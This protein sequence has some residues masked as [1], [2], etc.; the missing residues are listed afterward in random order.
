[1]QQFPQ[2]PHRVRYDFW[3]DMGKEKEAQLADHIELLKNRRRFVQTVRDGIRLIDDLRQGKLDVLFELFPWVRAEF[4]K[5]M[6]IP[7]KKDHV[8]LEAQLKRLEQLI[9]AQGLNPVTQDE[10]KPPRVAEGPKQLQVPQ[11]AAPQFDDDDDLLVEVKS[12]ANTANVAEN[13]IR[14]IRGLLQQ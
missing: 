8:D 2:S 12:A 4:F 10:A 7:V 14:S 6:Q 9:I 1:M 13:F 11:F 3:L 5:Y